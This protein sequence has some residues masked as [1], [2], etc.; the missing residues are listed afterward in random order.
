MRKP[1][2]HGD[3]FRSGVK[4]ASGTFPVAGSFVRRVL[5]GLSLILAGC[6]NPSSNSTNINFP[7][8]LAVC[9]GAT[10]HVQPATLTGGQT[11]VS[12]SFAAVTSYGTHQ[13]LIFNNY[14][15][16]FPVTDSFPSPTASLTTGLQGPN[17]L[18]ISS[19][20]FTGCPGP[21][22]YVS[23]GMTNQIS[24]WCG[25]NPASPSSGATITISSS[26]L[27]AP[28]GLSLDW[29]NG[30]GGLLSAPILFVA[31]PG[32]SNLVA[33]DLSEVSAGAGSYTLTP[34]G[35]LEPGT[36]GGLP[37]GTQA[38][39]TSLNAPSFLDFSNS[40]NTLFVSNT[41]NSEVMVYGSAYCVGVS[42]K[43]T[44]TTGCTQTSQNIQPS[45][46]LAGSN[47]Y[48][49]APEGIAYDNGSLY[50]A[51]SS[52]N[53]VMVWDRIM[54]AYGPGGN[55]KPTRLIN[56][57]NTQESGPYALAI[58]DNAQSPPGNVFYVS[59]INS[60]S[61]FGYNQATTVSG[62]IAPTF[63]VTVT[64]PGLK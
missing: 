9:S 39:G 42:G 33:F 21:V 1:V 8:G 54:T 10:C 52:T 2:L 38:N 29:V 32:G 3:L 41:G 49:S 60:G 55:I 46:R 28:E 26:S 53:S 13:V 51:D 58:D 11:P 43:S 5:W 25:F 47:T 16:V 4:S 40:L 56:G 50:V 15:T 63:L 23:D 44:A 37:F 59:Q 27:S 57:S 24:L 12:V 19:E 35:M 64:N 6:G 34:S 30:S 62:N 20:G 36:A 17:G 61:I 22:L 45:I 18:L 48:L 14:A 31:N 7:Y